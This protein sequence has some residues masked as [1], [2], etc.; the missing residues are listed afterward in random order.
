MEKN[1]NVFNHA[2]SPLYR[3]SMSMYS[4]NWHATIVYN[5]IVRKNVFEYIYIHFKCMQR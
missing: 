5:E 1:V 3:N 2:R 4:H